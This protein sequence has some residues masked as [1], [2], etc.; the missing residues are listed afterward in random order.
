MEATFIAI[1]QCACIQSFS[2]E[3]AY[4]LVWCKFNLKHT[5]YVRMNS[6]ARCVGNQKSHINIRHAATASAYVR[7]KMRVLIHLW[8]CAR[9]CMCVCVCGF[10]NQLICACVSCWMVSVQTAYAYQATPMMWMQWWRRRRSATR[11]V[12]FFGSIFDCQLCQ[13]HI[14]MCIHN[15]RVNSIGC[16]LQLIRGIFRFLVLALANLF[17][18]HGI[19]QLDELCGVIFFSNSKG[20]H[21]VGISTPWS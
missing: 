10:V 8:I 3:W 11:S 7:S 4:G 16:I 14:P 19:M 2:N 18:V 6:F 13:R 9:G 20:G 12:G 17:D 5:H 15:L 21:G 1:H